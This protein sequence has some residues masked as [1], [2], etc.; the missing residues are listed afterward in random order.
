MVVADDG[1]I[2]AVAT[3]AELIQQE[4]YRTATFDRDVDMTSKCILPGF[5]DGH[6]HPVFAGDRVHE[7]EMKLA[8]ATYMEIHQ[9]GGGIGYTVKHTR[10][11]SEQDLYELLTPRL[12]RM[13]CHGT[14]LVECKSGYGLDVD[15]ELKMLRV[16]TKASREHAI[17]IS[18]TFLGAHSVPAGSSATQATDDI[19]QKQLPA[20]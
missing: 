4:W 12:D 9:Q 20:L 14:T 3:E 18:A 10:Q 15:A 19:I 13:L 8:G 17:D 1:T 11:A 5:V 2:F 7:F 16:L 6:T